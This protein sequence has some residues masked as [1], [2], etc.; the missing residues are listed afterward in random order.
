MKI[1][2]LA[3]VVVA[4]AALAGCAGGLAGI[5][6]GVAKN[7]PAICAGIETA[8]AAFQT[9]AATQA[10]VGKPLASSVINDENAA[11]AGVAA[12]CNNPTATSTEDLLAK[13]LAAYSSVMQELAAAK[14]AK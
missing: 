2:A 10:S 14:S 11:F 3:A 4:G 9:I 6:A 8:D 12:I 5:E 7:L 1:I 13:V